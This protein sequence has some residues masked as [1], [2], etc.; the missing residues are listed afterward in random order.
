MPLV[1]VPGGRFMMGATGSVA[2]DADGEGPIHTIELSPY[3]IAAN[4]PCSRGAT[5]SSPMDDT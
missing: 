2:Y 5:S 4:A 3:R 1:E